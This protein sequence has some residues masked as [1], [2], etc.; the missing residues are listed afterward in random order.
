MFKKFLCSL[1]FIF[2]TFCSSLTQAQENKTTIILSDAGWDSVKFHNAVAEYIGRT[3]FDL[4][5]TTISGS[6]PIVQ[7]ALVRG[8]IDVNMEAWT[9][10]IP[11]FEADMKTGKLINLGIN[12]DD[13]RQGFYVPRYVIE[14]DK[15]RNIVPMAPDLKTVRDLAK[16]PQLFQDDENKDKGRIYG[17]IP[18]WGIDTILYKKYVA[19]ELDK[20]FIYFRSG[21][22]AALFT[23]FMAAY[24]KGEPI[25]GYCYEPTWISGKLDMVLLEDAPYSPEA[26]DAGLTEAR[27]VPVCVVANVQ[28]LEKSP[29]FASFLK[30]YRTSSALTAEALA[31]IADTKADYHTTAKWFLQNHP[32]LLMKWLPAHKAELVQRSLRSSEEAES[33]WFLHFPDWRLDF[34]G[35]IDNF[36]KH[37]NAK[38]ANF[39]NNIKDFLSWCIS[40]IEALLNLIPWW[41]TIFITIIAG[42][43]LTKKLSNGIFYGLGLFLIGI[44]GYWNMMNETLAVVIAAVVISLLIGLPIGVLVSTSKLANRLLRPFLD[45]MQTM[46]TFVYMIPAVM[47]LGPGKVPA[48]LATVVYAVVPV[49]R[50]TSHGIQQVDEEIVEASLAFGASRW[51]TLFKVQ[52]PQAMPTIMTGVNQTMMMAVA[53]VVTC[54]MIGANGLGMEVL[55]AINRTESGRGLIAGIS[56][57]I[58]AIIIDRLTQ[59]LAHKKEN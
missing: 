25:V 36:V 35:P 30:K 58:I 7:A 2:I 16:Y 23:A 5:F 18:G 49:I 37:I 12:F 54:A 20:D 31:Y 48:V 53:M 27:G 22:E 50:L 9:D 10:N 51:Q 33:N 1:F 56:I 59:S 45:A 17:A 43:K 32:E 26:F 29:E 14:G 38:Y 19:Y 8:D 55:I 47:L 24:T 39:F 44:F 21:S 3:A 46:P 42:K 4:N 40:S 15:A 13:D 52:I 6:T 28:L 11:T 41:L 57:V 34:T